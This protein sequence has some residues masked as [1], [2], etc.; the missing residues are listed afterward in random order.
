KNIYNKF[1]NIEQTKFYHRISSEALTCIELLSFI[2]N[3][4]ANKY[5]NTVLE[6]LLNDRIS[7]LWQILD[8]NKDP[9]DILNKIPKKLYIKK[10]FSLKKVIKNL[11]KI[12]ENKKT[13]IINQT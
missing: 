11:N 8:C 4:I 9:L 10:V 13:I 2:E 6:N 7:A 3:K 12:L 1:N 5:Q